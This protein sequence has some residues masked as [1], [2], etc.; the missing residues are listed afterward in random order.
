MGLPRPA[1]RGEGRTGPRHLGTSGDHRVRHRQVQRCLPFERARSSPTTGAT[2]SPARLAGSTSTTTTRRSTSRTWRASCGRSRRS[3]TRVSSTR[4]SACWRTAGVAR[5]RSATPRPGWTTPTAI[6]RIRRSRWPSNSRPASASWRGRPRRGR[7]RR[8]W[9]SPSAPTSTTRSSNSTACAT[10][11]P[12][13]CSARTPPNWARHNVSTP[14][15]GS[16]LVGR[17]YTPLFDFFADTAKWGTERAYPGAGRRLRLD[18]RRHRRR[19]HG[20]RLR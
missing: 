19:A 11:S 17:T 20:A 7:C 3:G 1:R 18:R 15:K 9:R 16:D 4:A 6:A 10:S 2:T 14:L 5:H 12:T 8:T 13:P